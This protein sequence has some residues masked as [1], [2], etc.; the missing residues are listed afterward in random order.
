MAMQ[1]AG[2]VN[3]P[4]LMAEIGDVR[5]FIHKGALLAFA[6]MDASFQSG[7][8]NSKPRRISKRGFPHPQKALFIAASTILQHF[9]PTNPIFQFMDKNR[10]RAGTLTFIWRPARLSFCASTMPE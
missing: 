10:P 8:L 7:A 3:E 6:G 9:D 1:G 4:Q 5:R 2:E